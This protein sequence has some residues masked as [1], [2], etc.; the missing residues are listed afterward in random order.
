[1][2]TI[3]DAILEQKILDAFQIVELI[4]HTGSTPDVRCVCMYCNEEQIKP[5]TAFYQY[6]M[7][8]RRR[9]ACSNKTCDAYRKSNT[10][11][12]YSQYKEQYERGCRA[13]GQ[14]VLEP[15]MLCRR[16]R[17]IVNRVGGELAFKRYVYRVID[18]TDEFTI[19]WAKEEVV[20]E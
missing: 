19:A 15:G 11:L 5:Y 12:T 17:T 13:C 10:D 14:Q 16:C 9:I 7:G 3:I 4:R 1:M 8:K 2:T 20:N 18:H 6:Y